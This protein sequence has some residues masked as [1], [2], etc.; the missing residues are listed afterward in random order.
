VG[1]A[2]VQRAF[3]GLV[4]SIRQLTG[5]NLARRLPDA[6]FGI[7]VGFGMIT[8]DRGLCSGAGH[9]QPG[10]RLIPPLVRP[11]RKNPSVRTRSV[12]A[13]GG[14]V[15]S[16]ARFDRGGSAR[17]IRAAGLRRLRRRSISAARNV[18]S[19]FDRHASLARTVGGRRVDRRDDRASQQRFVLSRACAMAARSG[20]A[21]RRTYGRRASARGLPPRLQAACASAPAFRQVRSG[22]S[23]AS[24]LMRCRT[25]LTI[26]NCV[27]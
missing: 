7:A 13:P 20:A 5:R 9:S 26:A 19:M 12:A 17:P 21:R 22:R 1:Q 11:K 24:P 23:L 2:G 14:A 15:A 16:G 27:K 10:K 18:P 25:W 6:R 3:L 4:E 8:Y